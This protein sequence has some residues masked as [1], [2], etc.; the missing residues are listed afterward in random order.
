MRLNGE[1]KMEGSRSCFFFSGGGA[2]IATSDDQGRLWL[3]FGSDSGF[4][5]L[6][7]LYYTRV[8]VALSP[9]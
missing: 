5:S 7:T 3:L 1:F 8:T 9:L 2:I 6:T 4:E